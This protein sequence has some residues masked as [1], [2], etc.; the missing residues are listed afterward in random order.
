MEVTDVNK[1]PGSEM[2]ND[3]VGVEVGEEEAFRDE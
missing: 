3:S 1:S 2:T